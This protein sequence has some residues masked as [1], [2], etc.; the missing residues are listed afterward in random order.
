MLQKS[1][2]CEKDPI[3]HFSGGEPSNKNAGV[4]FLESR[5]A[6]NF[7]RMDC[8]IGFFGEKLAPPFFSLILSSVRIL[9]K[10]S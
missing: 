7:S 6:T 10:L 9:S 5:L 1:R 3:C 2:N 4:S 8:P